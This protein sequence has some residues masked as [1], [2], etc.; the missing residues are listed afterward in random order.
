MTNKLRFQGEKTSKTKFLCLQ[1]S[2]MQN[3]EEALGTL[4]KRGRGGR[5]GGKIGLPLAKAGAV[6]ET[7]VMA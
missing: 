3:N 7:V 6:V 1:N 5:G 2:M 4:A